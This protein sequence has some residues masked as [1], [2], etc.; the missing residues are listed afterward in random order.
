[1]K[2]ADVVFELNSREDSDLACC[3]FLT[4][5]E[6]SN[7]QEITELPCEKGDVTDIK[8]R[9][10]ELMQL[11]ESEQIHYSVSSS[12]DWNCEQAARYILTGEKISSQVE[13]EKKTHGK[14]NIA[15]GSF[16]LS[17]GAAIVGTLFTFLAAKD[18]K[19]S[20][21]ELESN[22]KVDKSV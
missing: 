10:R 16:I 2:G 21:G 7:G 19:R 9:M 13:A 20:K 1:M 12:S 8:E 4:I 15:K 17:A 22:T 11:A 3:R 18:Y 5:E 6:F 14:Q